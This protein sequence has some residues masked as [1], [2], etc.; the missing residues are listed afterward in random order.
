MRPRWASGALMTVLLTGY[1][2][3]CANEESASPETREAYAPAIDPARFTTRIDNV[4]LPLAVGSR[5]VY[6]AR[7][8]EGIERVVVEVTDQTRQVMGVKT[9]VVR[10]VATLDGKA[11]E[12]T[13]DW[14]AQDDE[15]NVWYFGEETTSFEDG[16]SDTAGSWE[17]GVDGA[18]PGIAMKAGPK[19]GDRYRQEYAAGEAEDMGEV[20][21]IGE[22]VSV[23][24]RSFDDV[25]VTKDFSPLDP[26]AV[27]EKYYARGVGA[28]LVEQLGGASERMELVE[29]MR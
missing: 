28:V 6:E 27:E 12:D 17:A 16:K 25:L 21:R 2:G 5:W 11:V 7:V 1:L 19:V 24:D 14:Y 15:G 29:M 26:D 20:V 10:D 3:A 9:V 8:D 13:V 23:R 18:Q 4:Y 22:R